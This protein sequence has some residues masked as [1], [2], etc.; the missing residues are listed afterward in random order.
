M[1]KQKTYKEF[2]CGGR[3]SAYSFYPCR[4]CLADNETECKRVQEQVRTAKHE[5]YY[6]RP[7][8]YPKHHG[9]MLPHGVL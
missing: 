3:Y 9:E 1:R 8:I 4:I 5:E 6:N 2:G 7:N